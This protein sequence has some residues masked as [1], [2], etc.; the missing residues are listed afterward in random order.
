MAE[1]DEVDVKFGA[2]IGELVEGV[3]R[4]KEQIDGVGESVRHLAELFGIALTLDAFKEFVEHMAEL[5]EKTTTSMAIL[6]V[7]AETVGELQGVAK[8]TG[9]SFE[10]L[11]NSIGRMSLRL[12]QSTRDAFNPAA[13]GLHA[14]GINAKDLIGLPYDQ[15]LLKLSEA[16]GKLRPSQDLTTAATAAFGRGITQQLSMLLQGREHLEEMQRAWVETGAVMTDV[17]AKAFAETHEKLVLLGGSMEGLGIKIFSV[18]RPAIDAAVSSITKLIQSISAEGIQDAAN[19]TGNFIIDV[20]QSVS[21]FFIGVQETVLTLLAIL[22]N[23]AQPQLGAFSEFVVG[24]LGKTIEIVMLGLNKMAETVAGS[25]PKI[26]AQGAAIARIRE[27]A[28]KYRKAIDAATDAARAKFNQ[29]V[30]AASSEEAAMARLRAGVEDLLASY[31]KLDA[32]KSDPQA[33]SRQEAEITKLQEQVKAADVAY[34]MMSEHL[35]TDV[36]LHKITEDEKTRQLL[37]ALDL[38]VSAEFSALSK[39]AEMHK[40]DPAE[41]AKDQKAITDK[42]LEATKER[43]KITDDGVKAEAKSWQSALTPVQSAWDSQ[44]SGLLAHTTTWAQ[45]MK[46]IVRDLVLDMIK[47]LEKWALEKAAVQLAESFGSPINTAKN[48]QAIAGDLGQAYAGFV[49]NLAPVLGPGAL[50]AAAALTATAAA[51]AAAFT[52]ASAD[53]GGHVVSGGLAL[54]H[55][56]ED[57]VPASITQPYAGPGGGGGGGYGGGGTINIHAMDGADV[58]RVLTKHAGIVS[59]IVQGHVGANP[60]SFAR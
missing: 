24:S 10:G 40:G 54:I 32:G 47:A 36:T 26:D 56:G 18:L 19:K 45:A 37:S 46:N 30:P 15:Y 31:K 22:K 43:Q 13:Q 55:P 39:V 51:A 53:V 11:Q 17:Q 20:G 23:Q 33:K 25:S 35:S 12:Q 59:R 1:H 3:N 48:T 49:A 27:E 5:G 38:R 57:I 9:T 41:Y 2:Q 4:V 29:A 8:L 60:T 16:F 44:L 34:Q 14:L 52:V 6:G 21:K 58:L 28:E 50:E 7:S 42:L